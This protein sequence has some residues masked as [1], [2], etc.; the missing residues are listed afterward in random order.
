MPHTKHLVPGA[1][2]L[3][4]LLITALVWPGADGDKG[5]GDGAI[6]PETSTSVAPTQKQQFNGDDAVAASARRAAREAAEESSVEELQLL[7]DDEDTHQ[8]A[9]TK[10]LAMIN[11]STGEQM[12]AIDAFRWL[13]GRKAMRA[14]IQ[15]SNQGYG[16]VASEASHVLTHLMSQGLFLGGMRRDDD[17]PDDGIVLLDEGLYDDELSDE[18]QRPDPALWLEAIQQAPDEQTR[19]ALLTILTAYPIGES[20]PIFLQLLESPDAAL[21]DAA[22]EHLE[23]I[24]GG[25][26]ILNRE[27]GEEWLAKAAAADSP[28]EAA[29]D[30]PATELTDDVEE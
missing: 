7:L 27:Q 8:E 22:K 18:E 25:D 4:A 15:L 26:E 16:P 24:T 9:L 1:L 17:I 20:V 10:A 14:L 29:A 13:G 28:D 3:L 12:A 23:S 5:G 19:D 30:S 6:K 11:G 21:R 2:L